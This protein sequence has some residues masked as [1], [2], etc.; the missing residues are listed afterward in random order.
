MAE[1]ASLASPNNRVPLL[2]LCSLHACFVGLLHTQPLLPIPPR[3]SVRCRTG[4]VLLSFENSLHFPLHFPS[5]KSL[6]RT[7]Q[8][9]STSSFVQ[10]IQTVRRS[11]LGFMLFAD[12]D[13]SLD[14]IPY[15]RTDLDSHK[16]GDGSNNDVF[17]L[18]VDEK[19]ERNRGIHR[20]RRGIQI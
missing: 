4:A 14:S 16:R 3:T 13:T 15:S 18:L 7:F 17:V 6:R 1:G 8:G 5:K 9:F 20:R 19:N 10:A 2:M 11:S 12:M